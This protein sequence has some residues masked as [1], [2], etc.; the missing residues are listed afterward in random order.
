MFCSGK[1]EL[2][3]K[4]VNALAKT[5]TPSYVLTLRLKIE[6]YQEHQLS[7]RFEIARTIYNACLGELHKRYSSLRQ[8][9]RYSEVCKM[10]KGKQRN[11]RFSE[12]NKEFGLV[13]YSLHDFVKPMQHQFKI[14]IDAFTCQKI[15][16]RA[17]KAFEKLIYKQ[18]K[19]V[20]FKRYGELESV[21]GKSNTTGIRYKDGQIIWNGLVLRTIIK[22]NDVYAHLALKDK[23]K[24]VRIKKEWMKNK[25]V[26]FAQLVLE[27]TP[28]QKYNSEGIKEKCPSKNRVGIDIG[29]STV[30]VCSSEKVLLTVL[31]PSVE[32]LEKDIRKI[33]RA[34][35]RS[36]RATNPTKYNENGTINQNIRDKWVFSKRYMK[37]K[38]QLKEMQRLNRVRRKQDHEVLSNTII[39]LGENIF[40][41]TMSFKGL[42]KRAKETTVNKNGKF[43]RKKR[44]GKSIGNRAPGMLLSILERKLSYKN[45]DLKKVNTQLVKASQYNHITDSYE[46][47]KLHVR[48]NDFGFCKIQRDLYSAFLLMNSKE[49]LEEINKDLCVKH[50]EQFK[51]MHDREMERL[52]KIKETPLSMGV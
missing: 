24:F 30:A 52:L 19:K 40:V 17:F 13:E 14:N 39:S 25:Y 6:V 29:T 9:K 2:Y 8:S 1:M 22:K 34:L 41:E 5:K 44:F 18:S 49:N 51:I 32:T 35:D 7:K 27:G 10:D 38:A 16:T 36:K 43:N 11:K 31:A 37:K 21:E 26:Y 15:A 50:F 23:I 48:W 3:K 12:L 42:Q 4:V 45:K 28:P 20:R 46:K 33:Q 47:K